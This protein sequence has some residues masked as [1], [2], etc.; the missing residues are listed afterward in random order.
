MHEYLHKNL[1]NI[2]KQKKFIRNIEAPE[3]VRPPDGEYGGSL[4]FLRLC[5]SN[6]GSELITTLNLGVNRM[7]KSKA[8]FRGVTDP[9]VL[10]G[11]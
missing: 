6:Y 8:R 11:T 5:L 3:H 10:Y 4:S 9:A 2:K 7:I 1:E